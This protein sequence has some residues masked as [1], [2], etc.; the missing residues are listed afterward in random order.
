MDEGI[1]LAFE[2]N[3][4][5]IL[6]DLSFPEKHG[7]MVLERVKRELPHIKIIILTAEDSNVR[8]RLLALGA[9]AFFEKGE[10]IQNIQAKVDELAVGR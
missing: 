2:Q 7:I 9:D 3:P 6:L 1:R 5:V 4:N 8:G 10:P